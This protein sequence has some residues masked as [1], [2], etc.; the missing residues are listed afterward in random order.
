MFDSSAL[1]LGRS[2][3]PGVTR[4]EDIGR[5]SEMRRRH[6]PSMLLFL[7]PVLAVGIVAAVLAL[8]F[9]PDPAE[10]NPAA[11][12]PAPPADLRGPA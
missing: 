4:P 11:S 5:A 7:S 6:V 1:R 3:A 9:A 8:R 10:H 12:L 2:H